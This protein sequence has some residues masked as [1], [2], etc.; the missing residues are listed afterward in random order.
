MCTKYW[1][2]G[3][4]LSQA[5]PGKSLVWTTFWFGLMFYVPVNSYG[6]AEMVS[7]PNHKSTGFI[8]LLTY[9]DLTPLTWLKQYYLP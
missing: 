5:C 8:F 6:H 1:S 2:A 9:S 3:K 4:P 7:S